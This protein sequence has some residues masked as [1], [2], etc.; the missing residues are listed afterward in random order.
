MAEL[1]TSECNQIMNLIVAAIDHCRDNEVFINIL[2]HQLFSIFIPRFFDNM[3][4]LATLVP[5]HT[6]HYLLGCVNRLAEMV[7]DHAGQNK[8][9]LCIEVFQLFDERYLT[10][11]GVDRPFVFTVD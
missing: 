3:V 7:L 2:T 4:S 5:D 11:T 8:Q 10:L 9:R 6:S 1:L